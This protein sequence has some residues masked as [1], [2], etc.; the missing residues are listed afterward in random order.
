[1]DQIYKETITKAVFHAQP[2]TTFASILD[3]IQPEYSKMFIATAFL[4]SDGLKG[5]KSVLNG[6]QTKIICGIGGHISDLV[7]LEKAVQRSQGALEGKVFIEDR[8]FHPK[9]Y[10]F[11]RQEH[12]KAFV[13]SGNLTGSGINLNE[14]IYIEISGNKNNEV[15]RDIF[16]YFEKLWDNNTVPVK[17]FLCDFPNYS[18]RASQPDRLSEDDRELLKS[19]EHRQISPTF[20]FTN[21]VN[22]TFYNKGCQTLPTKYNPLIDKNRSCGLREK[23]LKIILPDS[24][25]YKGTLY[26]GTNNSTDYYQFTVVSAMGKERIQE[27]VSIGE[28]IKFDCFSETGVIQIS[29]HEKA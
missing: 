23:A 15:N 16:E 9:L 6:R 5:I 28:V 14:E 20:S 17:D 4:T 26:H 27:L 3:S 21:K 13:G 1:M 8:L 2:S 7:G 10:I 25:E 19:I 22:N 12:I 29:K 11:Q 24:S 18:C